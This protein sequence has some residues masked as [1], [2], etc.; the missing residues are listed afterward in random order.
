MVEA[1]K[2]AEQDAGRPLLAQIDSLDV[3]N[4]VSWRYSDPAGQLC[5]RLGI[6]P[7]RPVYGQ[8]GGES[9]VRYLHEAA[10]RIARGESQVAAICGAEAQSSVSNATKAGIE[11]PSTPF[12][13]DAPASVT[14]CSFSTSHGSRPRRG[15]PCHCLPNL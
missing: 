9:P 3:V 12:A 13:F 1:L 2:R 10:L 14:Q 11:L 8:V 6:T 15:A 5:N 7:V 4:L